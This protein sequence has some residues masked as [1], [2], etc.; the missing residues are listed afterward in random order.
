MS[1]IDLFLDFFTGFSPNFGY[2]DGSSATLKVIKQGSLGW[3]FD[4]VVEDNA[5]NRSDVVTYS[6][7]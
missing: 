3:R 4:L 6:L 2:A 7:Q 1:N 5:G